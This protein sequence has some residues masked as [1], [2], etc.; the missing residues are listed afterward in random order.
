MAEAKLKD[1]E[2]LASRECPSWATGTVL[3]KDKR[4]RIAGYGFLER[5]GTV[6]FSA[7]PEAV[8]LLSSSPPEA[9]A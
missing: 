6:T 5:D 1:I 9:G 7:S 3:L 8:A 4:G 2:L